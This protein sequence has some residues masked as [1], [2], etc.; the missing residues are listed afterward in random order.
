MNGTGADAGGGDAFGFEPH[1]RRLT[2]LAYR[3]LGSLAEAEDVVQDAFLRWHGADRAAVAEP[4]AFLS[5][6]VARLCLDRLKSARI[7]RETYVGPWLPEP[8]L[9]TDSLD[10]GTASEYAQDL[11]VA[12]MLVLERLSPLER[13]AFLLH[14]IFDMNYADIARTLERSEASCRQLVARARAHVRAARPR[15]EVPPDNGARVAEAFLAASRSGDLEKLA[16][17]LAEDAVMHTDGGG[18]KRAALNAICGR[19]NITRFVIG[20]TTKKALAGAATAR[21]ARV[22]G[23]PGFVVTEADGTVQTLAFEIHGGQIAAIY[24]VRNPEK[25]RHVTGNG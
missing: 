4:R 7:R 6:T 23:L 15:F 10:P 17:L 14:D 16:N 18:R 24:I 8:V 12:L 2:G 20:I 22:N 1:R 9:D 21:P 5:R 3:M 19:D 13:A 25:L 11:S